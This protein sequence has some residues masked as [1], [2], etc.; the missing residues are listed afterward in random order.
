MES[1]T[2]RAGQQPAGKMGAVQ[3]GQFHLGIGQEQA[4]AF[5][6]AGF[7]AV[8]MPARILFGGNNNG[9]AW[10]AVL[11][12]FGFRGV[13]TGTFVMTFSLVIGGFCNFD[14]RM[15]MDMPVMPATSE[16]RMGAG[17]K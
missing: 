4:A 2:G 1:R 15:A 8:R 17:R 7:V 10:F 11:M 6:F 3:R 16:Q 13:L 5:A 9:F 12:P 14:T